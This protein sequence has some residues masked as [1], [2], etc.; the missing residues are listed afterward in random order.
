MKEKNALNCEN[1][2]F[3]VFFLTL[4]HGFLF[5]HFWPKGFGPKICV[6]THNSYF[7]DDNQSIHS[8]CQKRPFYIGIENL[9]L[10]V[11]SLNRHFTKQIDLSMYV[12]GGTVTRFSVF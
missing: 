2:H 9:F 11:S 5:D 4:F 3:A 1:D 7:E 8:W 6:E 10:L 12:P